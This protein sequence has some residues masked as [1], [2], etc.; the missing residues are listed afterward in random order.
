MQNIAQ[1]RLSDDYTVDIHCILGKGST[2][3]VYGGKDLKKNEK[4]AVK[5]IEL[6]TINN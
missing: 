2:G 6:K 1:V 3:C 5:V 4:V